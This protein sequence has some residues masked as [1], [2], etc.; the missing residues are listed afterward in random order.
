MSFSGPFTITTNNFP[1]TPGAY[2]INSAFGAFPIFGSLNLNDYGM[3]N[4]GDRYIIMPGYSLYVGDGSS[5]PGTVRISI[6]N[7][8]GTR[9]RNVQLNLINSDDFVYLWYRG[10]LLPDQVS[11]L[12]LSNAPSEP[13]TT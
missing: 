9:I 1:C 8:N 5:T 10:N 11:G 12:A 4:C 13:T 6:N 7:T 2:Q 3:Q